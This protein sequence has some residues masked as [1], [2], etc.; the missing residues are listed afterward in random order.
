MNNVCKFT[1]VQHEDLTVNTL[2]FIYEKNV[3]IN[4][5][6]FRILSAFSICLVTAGE[7]VLKMLN[8]Q[9]SLKEGSLFF[10]FPAKSFS[11]E[12]KEDSSQ[13]FE[14]LYILFLG[15]G[16]LP[17]L[18]RL[19]VDQNSPV[20]EDMEFLIPFWKS[21]LDSCNSSNI[22]LMSKAVLLYTLSHL[23]NLEEAQDEKSKTDD[24]ISKIKHDVDTCYFEPDLSLKQVCK[25]YNY[26]PKYISG[27]FHRK[28]GIGFSKYLQSVRIRH[29]CALMQEGILASKDIAALV[30]YKD[31]LYFSKIFKKVMGCSPREHL[32]EIEQQKT[33][34]TIG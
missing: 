8:G 20:Y 1:S 4:N 33:L 25:E 2:G 9:Y 18:E 12:E 21:S 23:S 10:T 30:G 13:H 28:L 31:P 24:I 16:V 15:L 26:S 34:Q 14:Y 17:L 32:K 29:A 11:I 22:D 19:K 5:S 3:G 6:G 27:L 7:G